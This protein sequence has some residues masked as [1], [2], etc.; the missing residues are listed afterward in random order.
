MLVLVASRLLS[1]LFPYRLLAPDWYVGAGIELVN[2]SPVLVVGLLLLAW[3]TSLNVLY[4]E[5]EPDRPV[6]GIALGVVMQVAIWA[7][8]LV[9]PVQIAASI[10]V[11]LNHRDRLNSEW[12]IV[13]RQIASA[14][15]QKLAEPRL[16][17][18]RKM[19]SQLV[20]RRNRSR[21]QL[22]LNL[23]K[24]GLRVMVSALAVASVLHLARKLI[25]D[26]PALL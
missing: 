20:D 8:L 17:Q 6:V 7:Y 14:R 12:S 16:D 26:W 21:R 19:E 2:A 9:V 24:D 18:L 5:M 22:V 4:G 23:W 25:N 15:Q 13:Q 1:A 11:D 10:L 3:A